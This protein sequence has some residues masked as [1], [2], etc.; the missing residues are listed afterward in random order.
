MRPLISVII[1]AYN[2]ETYLP[3]C[4]DSLLCQ[5]L[6][7]FELIL[8]DDGSTDGTGAIADRYAEKDGRVKVIHKENGGG[9]LSKKPRVGGGTRRI[10]HL[11]RCR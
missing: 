6:S 11:R 10:Y 7:D 2:T 8:I 5:T 1:P 4:L 9:V 3:R